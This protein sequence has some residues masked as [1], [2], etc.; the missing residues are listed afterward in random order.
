MICLVPLDTSLAQQN[1]QPQ[2][3][4]LY[5]GVIP[6]PAGIGDYQLS[7][8]NL[9]FTPSTFNASLIKG[10]ANDDNITVYPRGAATSDGF[11]VDFNENLTSS[12]Y[13]LQWSIPQPL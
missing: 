2:A 4:A 13:S 9:P 1:Q 5:Q 11:I 6:L 10:N 12:D 3:Q 8:L 7:G